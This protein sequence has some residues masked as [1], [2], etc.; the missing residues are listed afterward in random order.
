MVTVQ[1]RLAHWREVVAATPCPSCGC[2][3]GQ[4]CVLEVRQ[5]GTLHLDR[6]HKWLR[7][8]RLP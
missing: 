7:P 5:A 3:A 2:A 1:V 4:P 6:L 8:T